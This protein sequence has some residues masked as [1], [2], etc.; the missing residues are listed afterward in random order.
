LSFK[1]HLEKYKISLTC[2]LAIE[3]AVAETIEKGRQVY[4]VGLQG[5]AENRLDKL[6]IMKKVPPEN[7][8]RDRPTVLRQADDYVDTYLIK[9]NRDI[10][11]SKGI[12]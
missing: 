7:L 5:Q 2:A 9:F 10:L 11:A 4:I 1:K 12:S 3:N 8:L 6:G